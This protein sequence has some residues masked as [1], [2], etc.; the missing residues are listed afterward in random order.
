MRRATITLGII[1]ILVSSCGDGDLPTQLRALVA[2]TVWPDPR[3]RRGGGRPGLARD[4]LRSSSTSVVSR[5]DQ[6]QIDEAGPRRSSSPPR[7]SSCSCPSSPPR[8]GARAPPPPCRGGRQGATGR[9]EGQR[10][11]Q[12]ERRRRPRQGRLTAAV[13]PDGAPSREHDP[14]R[15]TN[16][17]AKLGRLAPSRE[18]SSGNGRAGVREHPSDG[19]HPSLWT[20]GHAPV[21]EDES[22]DP[23]H[24]G[25]PPDALGAGTEHE[26]GH[27]TDR[28]LAR[29]SPRGRPLRA[30]RTRSRSG[31]GRPRIDPS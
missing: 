17:T 30:A 7:S 9:R 10:Q 2:R 6:G 27:R 29:S 24:E 15:A 16:A 25:R 11:G 23:R 14:A 18:P 22:R 19:L 12:G 5:L 20:R 13:R 1:A 26:L 3:I 8:C 31:T 4:G 28:A 21:V